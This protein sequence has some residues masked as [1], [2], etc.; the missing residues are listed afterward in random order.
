MAVFSK[1]FI[2][3]YG[4]RIDRIADMAA[5][6]AQ[7]QLKYW[8]LKQDASKL[9]ERDLRE[10][11]SSILSEC[12]ETYGAVV[13]ELANVVYEITTEHSGVDAKSVAAYVLNSDAIQGITDYILRMWEQEQSLDGA[14]KRVGTQSRDEVHRAANRATIE[15]VEY[16]NAYELAQN[17]GAGKVRYARVLSGME[18]CTWCT[19]L[20]SRGF[21]YHTR[22]AASKT[23]SHCD[24]R[25]IAGVEGDSI[26]GYDLN[27]AY[28]RWQ[29]FEQIDADKTLTGKEKAAAKAA[30]AETHPVWQE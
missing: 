18:N 12:F 8:Y 27:S 4:A 1:A 15:N 10:K 6:Y 30:Y 11:I 26:E 24:C 29:A 28:D 20:A 5:N 16:T 2:D 19:M 17:G 22:E 9:T 13:T 23:H 25:I 21:V 3:D 7:A 14:I